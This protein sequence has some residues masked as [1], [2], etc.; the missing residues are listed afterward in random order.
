MVVVTRSTRRRAALAL[1]F[2]LSCLLTAPSNA[3]DAG[4]DKN[5]NNNNNNN[6]GNNAEQQR[7]WPVPTKKAERPKMKPKP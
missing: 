3:A 6:N 7:G 2:S 5:N 4:V 1:L